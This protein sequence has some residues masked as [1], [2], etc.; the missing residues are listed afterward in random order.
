M[1]LINSTTDPFTTQVDSNLRLPRLVSGSLGRGVWEGESERN[2]SYRR[3]Y[4]HGKY[5]MH[6]RMHMRMWLLLK[7]S[8]RREK[9]MVLW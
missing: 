5:E 9:D 8:N 3:A 4:R 2:R 7:V 6:V 1:L